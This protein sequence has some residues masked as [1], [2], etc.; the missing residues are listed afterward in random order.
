MR[1]MSCGVRIPLDP[2]G[3]PAANGIRPRRRNPR[4]YGRDSSER[5]QGGVRRGLL[6][7][8]L[9]ARCDFPRWTMPIQLSTLAVKTCT[10]CKVDKPCEDFSTDQKRSDGKQPW[11]K[12]CM[13]IC[14]V[15]Y[16]ANPKVKEQARVDR[17]RRRLDP[18]FRDKE[19]ETLRN[20][21]AVDLDFKKEQ[22]VYW[23][24]FYSKPE[25]REARKERA[26]RDRTDVNVR[27][28]Q[29]LAGAKQRD[30]NCTVTL[31]HVLTGIQRGHCPVTGIAFDLTS[32]HQRITGR[33]RN[34][35]SPSID[36]ID[37]RL[38][39]TNENTRIVI[40]HYNF[41]KGQLSD[42]EMRFICAQVVARTVC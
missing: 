40:T 3:K 2:E 34:P 23:E 22:K 41:M 13:A 19:N 17:A 5:R 24:E 28:R 38:G 9:A 21:R 31:E 32:E 14:A 20:R 7:L 35:Y 36:R 11:C 16:R 42:E 29:L 10:K 12:E 18:A 1:L 4:K 25:N 27:A 26:R 15:R 33:S 37:S 8:S 6:V 39:Y 30:S